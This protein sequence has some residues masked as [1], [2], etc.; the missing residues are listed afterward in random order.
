[1]SSASACHVGPFLFGCVCASH[2][3]KRESRRMNCDEADAPPP[4]DEGLAGAQA[5]AAALLEVRVDCIT[6]FV[7][8]RCSTGQDRTGQG[9]TTQH[10]TDSTVQYST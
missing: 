2:E 3:E 1:M 9:S 7:T 8:L 6:C 5:A 4:N 10:S